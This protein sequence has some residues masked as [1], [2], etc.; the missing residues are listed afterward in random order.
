M[1]KGNV[2]V[3]DAELF[4]IQ[5]FTINGGFV[6]KWGG[7][8]GNGPTEFSWLESVDVDSTGN[9]YVGRGQV[10]NFIKMWGTEGESDGQTEGVALDG[11][12]NVYVTDQDNGRIQKFTSDGE[13][14]TKWG[15]SGT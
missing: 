9:V 3:N 12:D 2:Y 6:T 5:K 15:S 13:F 11:S 10:G 8:E 7:T 14:I 4:N 1:Q